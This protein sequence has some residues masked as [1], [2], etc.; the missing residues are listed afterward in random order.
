MYIDEF[1]ILKPFDFKYAI[2]MQ[3]TIQK[4]FNFIRC[5]YSMVTKKNEFTFFPTWNVSDDELQLRQIGDL[6]PPN[7]IIEA[8]QEVAEQE[9]AKTEYDP[10]GNSYVVFGKIKVDFVYRSSGESEMSDPTYSDDFLVK[11]YNPTG[12][13]VAGEF[14]RRSTVYQGECLGA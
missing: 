12:N 2:W 4:L 8:A 14:R 7:E 10:E 5:S 13:E 11:T 6:R 1:Y 3:Y 9:F